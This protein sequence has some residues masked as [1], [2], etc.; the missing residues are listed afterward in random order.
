MA[1]PIRISAVLWAAAWL[2]CAGGPKTTAVKAVTPDGFARDQDG[3]GRETRFLSPDGVLFSVRAIPN[4]P[5]ADLAF[6]KTALQ[7]RMSQ[8]GYR[9]L[10]DSMITVGGAEGSLLRLAAPLGRTDYLYLV[11]LSLRGKEIRVAEAAG[12][13]SLMKAREEAVLK[14]LAAP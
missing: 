6:W 10:G 13:A 12:E 11:A 1:N 4:K 9:V 8:A 3:A 7:T 14:A 5:P 2:G